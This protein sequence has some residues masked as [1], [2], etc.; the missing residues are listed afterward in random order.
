VP[1]LNSQFYGAAV[2]GT[3]RPQAKTKSFTK[4]VARFL[5]TDI[6]RL[7]AE[8]QLSTDILEILWVAIVDAS[9]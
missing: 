6:L 9:I 4:S 5:I 3:Y 7:T 2:G 8:E 1:R